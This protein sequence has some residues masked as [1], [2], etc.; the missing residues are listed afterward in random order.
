MADGEYDG[1]LGALLTLLTTAE[2]FASQ[3]ASDALIARILR[4]FDKLPAPD[5]EP[6]LRILEREA[7]WCRI[8]EQT[9]EAT[10]ITV[11]PN[12]HASLYVHVFGQVDEPS[13][14][15]QRDIDVIRAGIERFLHLTPLLMQEG[16]RE[17]WT[18]SAREIARD[19]DPALRAAVAGIAHAALALV[20]EAEAT[21][22]ARS[23]GGQVPPPVP[24]ADAVAHGAP[25]P[26][27]RDGH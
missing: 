2:R 4:A 8:V 26:V 24:P 11:R 6:I 13:V 14:P 22:S 9:S 19:A 12:P 3:L 18:A 25:T 16:V 21:A 17:Q 20:A 5:R 7:A 27:R 10:G 23:G 15:L 1:D